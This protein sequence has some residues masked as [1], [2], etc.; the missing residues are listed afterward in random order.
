MLNKAYNKDLS[1]AAVKGV[2]EEPL[3]R[4]F[5]PPQ[6][7]GEF[8][9]NYNS[10]YLGQMWST[11]EVAATRAAA[12][13]SIKAAQTYIARLCNLGGRLGPPIVC[14]RAFDPLAFSAQSVLLAGVE[15]LQWLSDNNQEVYDDFAAVVP[16]FAC[17]SPKDEAAGPPTVEER[18][19]NLLAKLSQEDDTTY[20]AL[21]LEIPTEAKKPLEIYTQDLSKNS[22]TPET[23]ALL[24]S[25]FSKQEM[26]N[27][28]KPGL[29]F[30]CALPDT[31]TVRPVVLVPARKESPLDMWV[32]EP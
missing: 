21:V 9:N 19:Q 32:N 11:R 26:A 6:L 25:M 30:R 15:F 28:G 7:S 13:M 14:K 1:E 23:K 18:T 8:K 4:V 22:D 27:A 29:A 12:S 24:T 16:M 5:G 20:Q 2:Y 10:D 3:C 17:P 31:F